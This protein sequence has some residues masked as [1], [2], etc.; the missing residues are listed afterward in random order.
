MEKV[1]LLVL[2]ALFVYITFE[3]AQWLGLVNRLSLREFEKLIGINNGTEAPPDSPNSGRWYVINRA[4][5]FLVFIFV[6]AVCVSGALIVITFKS[7]LA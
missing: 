4:K 7:L 3:M 2:T 1:L 5:G 6:L